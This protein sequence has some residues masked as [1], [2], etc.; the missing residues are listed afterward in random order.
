MTLTFDLTY[1]LDLGCFKVK[2]WNSCIS[3]IV[4]LIDLEW[5]GSEL[6]WFWA[7]CMTLPFHHTHDL[8]LGSFKVRVWYSFISGMGRL[9]D[10]ERK[11]CESSIQDHDID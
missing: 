3:E 7:D 11:G 5:K 4:G 10:M 8:D 9:I 2:F 1:D 6:I